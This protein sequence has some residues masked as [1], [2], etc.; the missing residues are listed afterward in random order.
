MSMIRLSITLLLLAGLLDAQQVADTAFQPA[1]GAPQFAAG[2]GPVV[3]LDE[4]HVNFHTLDGRY[5]SFG[6]LLERDGFVVRPNRAPFARATLDSARVLV[7]A[8]ALARQNEQEWRLPNPSAFTP[9]EIRVVRDWVHAGGSLFLIADHMPFPGAA[10]DLAAEFGVYM[11]NGYARDSTG[12]TGQMRFRR[13]DGTLGAHPVISGRNAR[14][15]IDSLTSF[16]GQAFRARDGATPLM[17]LPAKT[18][19]LLPV[20]AWQFSDS[21]P[22]FRADG[23]LQGA[24]LEFGRG[25]VVVLGEAAMLSAQLAGPQRQPMGMNHPVAAQNPQFA[26]NVVRWLARV[27]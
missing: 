27:Y 16:T 20:V 3:L 4:A 5:R 26:L 10:E 13:A 9:E 21:T 17:T 1:V 22:H 19:N 7:I 2:R 24:A 23:M 14:E 25:R 15:R 8:N 12:S 6:L 11:T 18:V